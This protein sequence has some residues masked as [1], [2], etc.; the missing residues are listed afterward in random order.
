MSQ[1]PK[2][3]KIMKQ[4]Q[5]SEPANFIALYNPLPYLK[6]DEFDHNVGFKKFEN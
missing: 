3:E 2:K 6:E 5:P 1:N 4:G